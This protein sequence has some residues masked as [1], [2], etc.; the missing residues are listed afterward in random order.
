MTIFMA[1]SIRAVAPQQQATAMGVYQAI[2]A[3]GMLMGPLVSGSL[4]D[5]QGLDSVF[6]LSAFLCLVIAV[7]A[8]LPILPKR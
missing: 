2:Y 6:Y 8:C 4:A 5:S 3:I 1:L 7:I